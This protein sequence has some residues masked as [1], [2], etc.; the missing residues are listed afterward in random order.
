MKGLREMSV[1]RALTVAPKLCLRKNEKKLN[2]TVRTNDQRS[3][4]RSLL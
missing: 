4:Q 3:K 1:C 2:I